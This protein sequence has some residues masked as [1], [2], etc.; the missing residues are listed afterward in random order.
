MW[1]NEALHRPCL[2]MV[3]KG[4][5]YTREGFTKWSIISVFHHY[6]HGKH[7]SYAEKIKSCLGYRKAWKLRGELLITDPLH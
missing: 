4:N 1:I 2:I 7:I 3:A 5:R 6:K